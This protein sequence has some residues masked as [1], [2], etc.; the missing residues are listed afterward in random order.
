M[1][2]TK[3]NKPFHFKSFILQPILRNY[4][5][6]WL[7]L[8]CI[9]GI[10]SGIA[11]ALFLQSLNWA[12]NFRNNHLW[13]IYLLP[14]SGLIIGFTYFKLGK[15]V[16]AG[17]N[18]LI[19]TI[20]EPK[21]TVPFKMAPLVYLSTIVTHLFGGSAGREGTALQMSGAI[22]DQ[23]S[24]P[25]QL[26]STDRKILITAAIAAGF[27]AVFGTPIAG[28][29][30]ANEVAYIKKI[31]YAA[32]IPSF[33]TAFIAHEITK[34]CGVAHTAYPQILINTYSISTIFY[35]IIAGIAFGLTATVFSKSMHT[36]T[37]VF[38]KKIPY[39]PIRPMIGGLLIV[40]GVLAV[41]NTKYNGLGLETI[42]AS[43]NIALPYYDFAL[44]I[45]FTV[46]TLSSGFK[47]GEVTP[48]FFIGATLGNAL[49]LFIPLPTN[50]LAGV[51]F[52]AVF[53]GATNT[54]IACTIMAME[55]MGVH[56]GGI[57]LITCIT[58]Y[59]TASKTG[60]YKSQV[61]MGSKHHRF[62]VHPFNRFKNL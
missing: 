54:P 9:V 24:K 5:V 8:C 33:A 50:V 62:T 49:S 59:L 17:N 34:L 30:F 29:I 47:G 43:F 28:A 42:N 36:L 25:F 1:Q 2:T 53:A 10:T 41:G 12:T 20:H 19:A 61:F 15:N 21:Q 58:A 52:V 14:F 40:V 26:T 46:A 45:L 22:A 48:L 13:L 23:C 31:N 38:K 18:I 35:G 4:F 27:G 39:A 3:Q 51:G 16:A 60:I 6:K 57:A 37:D 55:L 7:L 11:A 44:K 56:I 32:I